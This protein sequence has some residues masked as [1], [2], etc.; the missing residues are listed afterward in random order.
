[1]L[2]QVRWLDRGAERDEVLVSI[3]TDGRVT[4]WSIAKGLE[5]QDIMRLKRVARRWARGEGCDWTCD[6]SHTTVR[7]CARVRAPVRACVGTEGSSQ[8]WGCLSGAQGEER[9]S[10]YSGE[11]G[12]GGGELTGV[13]MFVWGVPGL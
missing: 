1:M 7:A 9:D 10:T 3:S 2:A 6:M 4:Q 5:C 11:G 8:G 12:G 13:Q